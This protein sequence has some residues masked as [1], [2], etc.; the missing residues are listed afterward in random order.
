[1][2]WLFLTIAAILV[3]V[4]ITAFD[5]YNFS[6]RDDAQLADVAI[7]LGAGTKGD[8][9]PPVFAERINHAIELYKAGTVKKLIMTGGN[10][11][12]GYSEGWVARKIMQLHEV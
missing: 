8:Q 2:R 11:A 5:I 9:P 6:L 4:S 12:N 1:M 10:G 3:I 7:V